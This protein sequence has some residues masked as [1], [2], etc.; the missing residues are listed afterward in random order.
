MTLEERIVAEW[1]LAHNSVPVEPSGLNS[2]THGVYLGLKWGQ[3]IGQQVH[4]DTKDEQWNQTWNMG[5]SQ[6][7]YYAAYV[8][9]HLS[10]PGESSDEFTSGA[11]AMQDIIVE[12]CEAAANADLTRL[13]VKVPE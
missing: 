3:K 1:K 5:H 11:R 6:G 12:A 4:G 9:S 2:F 10:L 7:C 8:A 13:R